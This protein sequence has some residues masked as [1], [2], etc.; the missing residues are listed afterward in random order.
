ITSSIAKGRIERMELAEARSIPGVL[1]IFTRE[2]T[3]ELKSGRF[4]G[5]AST[6]IDSL[7]PDIAHDGQIVAM[8]VANTYEAAREAAYRVKISYAETMPSASFESDDVDVVDAAEVSERHKHM[9]NAGDAETEL[10]H[11]A[12]VINAEYSTPTQHH[13]PLELFTTTCVWSGDQLTIHE[14]SQFVYGL[15]NAV[16]E[17][18]GIAAD[19]VRVVSHYV[20]GAFGSKGTMTP[21]TALVALAARRI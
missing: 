20:G 7:G 10:E 12:V 19:K 1:E 2:N 8:V 3:R 14:P 17:R 21:R 15:K 5:G 18:L 9:P 11:A 13:N 4:G 16:A 6:S